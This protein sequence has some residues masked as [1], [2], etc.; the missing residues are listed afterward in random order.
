MLS[1][2][3]T[4]VR[5][6]QTA[7]TT[8]SENIANAGTVGYSRRTTVLNE[9]AAPSSVTSRIPNG[10]GVVVGGVTRAADLYRS[11]EVRT[12]G[13]DLARSE[14]GAAWLDRIDGALSDNKLGD[15]LT[16]FF[17]STKAIAADPSALAP[18][19]TTLEAAQS[20]ATAFSATGAALSAAA[21]DLDA[22]A[23]AATTQL[24]G[25]SAALAKVNSGLSRAQAGSAANATLLDQ[26]DQILESMSAITDVS[27][28]FDGIG[29]ATVKGGGEGGPVLV[30]GVDSATVS[31]ARN[32]EGAVAFTSR[33]GNATTTLSP[34]G[35]ALAGYAD[36]AQKIAAAQSQL[37]DQAQAFA[38][39]V[40]AVQAAGVDLNGDPG[41]PIFQVGDPPSNLT[42]VLNDPH[43][44]AAAAPGAGTR[45]NSNLAGF[46][47]LRATGNVEG[48]IIDM[49]AAN[50]AALAAKRG[51][52]EAQGAIRDN[53]VAARDSVSG[54]NID[55]EAVDLMRFQQAYQAS[56]RV[57]QVARE[58][59][60]SILEIR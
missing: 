26:R 40:N 51:V 1:I 49:T 27:V 41:Q 37:N 3:A 44:I 15:R 57:I 31:Y 34:S 53:A 45:D 24:N 60:Q 21:S 35:G 29:R 56:S 42:M 36:G 11:A 46:D 13:S 14:A 2:G 19:A 8:T 32:G 33:F 16:A 28:S 6:Y 52:A 12:A 48:A 38:D 23:D 17:A 58:T 30:Q 50:G 22:S 7:L 54:V 25:L 20:V 5:A 59:F 47:T 9:V 10:L 39:G 4:G 55:E 43:G 18:R